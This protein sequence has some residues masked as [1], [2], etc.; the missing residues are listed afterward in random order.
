MPFLFLLPEIFFS[1]KPMFNER[2]PVPRA[3]ISQQYPFIYLL[4]CFLSAR[5]V[6]LSLNTSQSEEEHGWVGYNLF[7]LTN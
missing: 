3:T 4:S 1:H 6:A 7:G 5:E 2:L